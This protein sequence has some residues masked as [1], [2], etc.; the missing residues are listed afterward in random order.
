MT[1]VLKFLGLTLAFLLEWLLFVSIVVVFAIRSAAVQTFLAK[2]ATAYLEAGLHT[3]VKIAAVDIVLF[4]YIDLKGVEIED[5]QKRDLLKVK[6]LFLGIKALHFFKND[7]Q[8]NEL[9]FYQGNINLQR[10]SKTGAYNYQFLV[11]YFSSPTPSPSKTPTVQIALQKIGLKH[12]DFTY[13]D[14]RFYTLPFG[15]DYDHIHLKDL[16]LEASHFQT[17][18]KKFACQLQSIGFKDR[19][20][21]RLQKLA[22]G[23]LISQK[24]IELTHATLQTKRSQLYFPLLA[25]RTKSLSD[26]DAF[27]DKVRFDVSIAPSRVSLQDIAYFAPE[28]KGMDATVYLS[29]FVQKELK[30]LQIQKLDLRVGKHTYVRGNFQLPDF[31]KGKTYIFNEWVK[32]AHIDFADLAALNMPEGTAALRIPSPLNTLQFVNLKNTLLTGSESKLLLRLQQAHTALGDLSLGSPLALNRGENVWQLGPKNADSTL[33]K[34]QQFDLGPLAELPELGACTGDVTAEIDIFDD[35]SYA[36]SQVSGDLKSLKFS[37]YLY[38]AIHFEKGRIQD[39]QLLVDISINDPNLQLESKLDL[40]L[41]ERANYRIEL[42]LAQADLGALHIAGNKGQS[43]SFSLLADFKGQDLTQLTG[44][45]SAAQI[46]YS[47]G[48]KELNSELAQVHYHNDAQGEHIHLSSSIFEASL[49]GYI[50]YTRVIDDF[51]H[52][53][54]IVYPPLET[55]AY[56]YKNSTSDFQ[57]ELLTHDSRSFLE[58]FVPGLELAQGTRCNVNFQSLQES[59]EIQLTSPAIAYEGFDFEGISIA[60]QITQSG[61]EGDMR[62]EEMRVA[63]STSFHTLVFTNK[64][65]QGQLQS[66]LS[67]DPNTNDYSQLKWSTT[68]VE[69]EQLNFS[70]QPSF[71]TINGVEWEIANQSDIMLASNDISVTNFELIRGFQRIQ[72]NGCLSENSRDQLRFDVIGLDLDELSNLLGSTT[73]FSGRFS[74]WGS[75]ATPFTNLSVMADANLENFAIDH[76]DVGNIQL[77][78]DWNDSRKSILLDGALDYRG[79][80]T[81]NFD[82]LYN[83]KTDQLDLGLNFN[84]TDIQFTNAFLDPEVVQGIQG[85]LNGRIRVKGSPSSPELSGKLRLQNGAATVSLLGVSY[86]LDGLINVTE[87]AFLMDNIP[88]KDE[89]G[90]TAYLSCAVNHSNFTKWNYDVQINFE[91][92]IRKIDPRTNQLIPIDRFMVLNTKY[93]EGD[94]YYGKAYGR[95][96]ANIFGTEKNLEVTVDASTRKG[97]EIIF[98]MYGMSEIEEDETLV[99]FVE[100]GVEQQLDNRG[101]DL[102]GVDLDLDFHITQ[103]ANMKLIFNEQTGDEITAKGSGD[104]NIKL[105]QYNNL[106]MEGPYVIAKGSRYNFALGSIKQTFDIE[107][108]S[109]IQWT[110]DPYDADININTVTQKRA[111]ILELSPE[112]QDNSLV[113]QEVFCYL[114][115]SE[116]LLSPK[117]TFDIAAPRVSE[118]G[119]ALIDRVKSDPDELNRQFFSL[120][121]VSKFQPLKGTISAG[122]SA[123]LDLLESQINAALGKLSENYKLNFDYGSDA[124]L[125]ESKVEVGVAKGFLDD[126]LVITGSFGV[127]NKSTGTSAEGSKS[128]ANSMIGD[129]NI[130]YKIQENFRVRAFNQSNVNSVNENRG[131]FTQGIGVSYSDEFQRFSDMEAVKKFKQLIQRN[132]KKSKQSVPRKH[133]Q[134]VSLPSNEKSTSSQSRRDRST[135]A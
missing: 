127:E 18:G 14:Q 86:N 74:G 29:G 22:A 105:D 65:G 6:H 2:E 3:K 100:H 76:Q 88:V 28:I 25:L 104:L 84:Q 32:Q 103:D 110:G 72:L 56:R 69:D 133:R 61:I 40:S 71:F 49:D 77:H 82:G 46:Q 109:K 57:L 92:D 37:D 43:L 35:G 115:L 107:Q 34:L 128:Y 87:D 101:I 126:K 64:G 98:P 4:R 132:S 8:F 9:R 68:L 44:F 73:H 94:V 67:W 131:P 54:S 55:R 83:L 99:R 17:D 51:L 12:I 30:Q 124:I 41:D 75:L 91:D 118:T 78:S 36:L 15:I 129:V 134:P 60:Q 5:Q 120:L 20:G 119:K 114:K 121:L 47:D 66:E 96:T 102:T 11:D 123:A 79:E 52:H 116:S 130:E 108:G 23:L 26:F 39:D 135:R 63:D 33:F 21:F 122:G 81:F 13:D 38:S 1:K 53:L 125:G 95:G 89:E 10:D 45:A 7:Y 117:I 48:Q 113:N 58:L 90:N 80:R 24:G 27:D 93:V 59:L 42:E 50:D 106:T 111:S 112:I 85:K 62:I 19:S 31:R 97:T 16:H 70:L